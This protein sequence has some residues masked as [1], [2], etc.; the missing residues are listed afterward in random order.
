MTEFAIRYV[1]NSS[2][3]GNNN[4]VEIYLDSMGGMPYT[5]VSIPAT[6]SNWNAYDVVQA[7][8]DKAVTG[9]HDVYFK[10]KTDGGNAGYVANIDW[11]SFSRNVA[12]ENLKSV[13][14]D[15]QDILKEK[16]DYA[17]ADVQQLQD[18]VTDAETLLKKEA[19]S[20]EEY[21][22][23]TQK[24]NRAMGRMHKIAD[25]SNL[26]TLL[27]KAKA[28]DSTHWTTESKE[29][30]KAAVS[31]GED[32]VKNTSATQAQVTLAEQKLQSA[33]DHGQDM[34]EGN[35][36]VLNAQISQG[37]AVGPTGY[38]ETSYAALQDALKKAETVSKDRWAQQD[39]IEAAVTAIKTA[40]KELKEK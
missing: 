24:L 37:T 21:Q 38:T 26:K 40:V 5:I 10:L 33:L 20:Q 4:R 12:L 28:A 39:D 8:L 9:T 25:I 30:L 34:Q 35:K 23:A 2:R 17:E 1:N 19:A 13:Y 32:I 7:Q 22:S 11:F 3:C 14:A 36:K 16:A 6:G 29:A 31:Y 15:A 27:E 18:A